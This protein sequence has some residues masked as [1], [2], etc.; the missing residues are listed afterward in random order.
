VIEAVAAGFSAAELAETHTWQERE[1]ALSTCLDQLPARSSALVAER[2]HKSRAIE[3]LAEEFG[4][5]VD[6]IYRSAQPPTP[7]A[8]RVCQPSP[9]TRRLS[10][11]HPPPSMDP[12]EVS[13]LSLRWLDGVATDEERQR[14]FAALASDPSAALSLRPAR[15]LRAAARERQP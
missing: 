11:M 4:M 9:A 10:S 14:L 5:S 15:P 12:S 7:P 2:Y 1:S 3:D 6:G 13:R 8:A